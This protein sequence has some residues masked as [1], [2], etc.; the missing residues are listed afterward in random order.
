MLFKLEKRIKEIQIYIAREGKCYVSPKGGF[1]V[2]FVCDFSKI[3]PFFEKSPSRDANY[4]YVSVVAR[5]TQISR[6]FRLSQNFFLL[7]SYT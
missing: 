3:L 6:T 4:A 1:Y 5:K 7:Y 2:K